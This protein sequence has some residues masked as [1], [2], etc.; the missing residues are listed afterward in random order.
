[1]NSRIVL[2]QRFSWNF[3]KYITRGIHVPRSFGQ[4]FESNNIVVSLPT[5]YGK[6]LSQKKK[7]EVWK[8][9]N[10]LANDYEFDNHWSTSKL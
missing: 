7:K 5:E 1:M 3:H 4:D 10:S 2:L 8:E 6:S 9:S